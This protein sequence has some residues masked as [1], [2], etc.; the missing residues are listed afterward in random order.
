MTKDQAARENCRRFEES[1][2][3][4]QDQLER[5]IRGSGATETQKANMVHTLSKLCVF[6]ADERDHLVRLGTD[7]LYYSDWLGAV[8]GLPSVS[9]DM[10]EKYFEEWPE[11]TA[12]GWWNEGRKQLNVVIREVNAWTRSGCPSL[13]AAEI[14]RDIEHGIQSYGAQDGGSG[15]A[16]ALEEMRSYINGGGSRG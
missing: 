11:N 16:D 15:W 3:L 10:D 4:K 1:R 13:E 8:G 6:A 5:E 12:I 2:R 14:L 9:T 7:D